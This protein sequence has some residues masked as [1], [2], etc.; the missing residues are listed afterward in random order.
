[1]DR[2]QY[3]ESVGCNVKDGCDTCEV[4]KVYEQGRADAI[5]E[6]IKALKGYGECDLADKITLL[7]Q[8]KEKNNE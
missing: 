3:N 6:C 8:L 7:E 4:S 5:D 2:C 1:M